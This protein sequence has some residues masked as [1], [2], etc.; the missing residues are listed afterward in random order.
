M[1]GCGTAYPPKDGT[2]DREVIDRFRDFLQ[3]AGPAVTKADR[4]AGRF[5]VR[6]PAGRYR[7]KFL[8]WRMGALG[9]APVL[10]VAGP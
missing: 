1:R 6:T 2:R 7:I 4:E 5:R 8:A 10:E 3:E 9:H